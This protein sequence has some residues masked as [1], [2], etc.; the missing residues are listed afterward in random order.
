MR[1]RRDFLKHGAAVM[2]A[3]PVAA[4]PKGNSA[5][6]KSSVGRGMPRVVVPAQNRRRVP[7]LR[8]STAGWGP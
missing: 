7:G 2:V 3:L 1:S 6:G 5:R 8:K 4:F